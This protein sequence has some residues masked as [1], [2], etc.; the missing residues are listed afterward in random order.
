MYSRVKF[1]EVGTVFGRW[2]F[3][4]PAPARKGVT[5]ISVRCTCGSGIV[6]EVQKSQV[7]NGISTSCGCVM[8]EKTRASNTKHGLKNTPIYGVWR[9]MRRRCEDQNQKDYIRYGGRGVRVCDRWQDVKNFFDDM[10][11]PPPGLSIERLDNSRGYE[12]GNCVWASMEE[13]SRN[14]RNNVYVEFFGSSKILKDWLKITGHS[15]TT[16][17][18]RIRSGLLPGDALVLPSSLCP[19]PEAVIKTFLGCAK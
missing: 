7:T 1:P 16:I 12:P 19:N 18:K 15:E 5:Y 2:E 10:G 4:G 13:Q 11:Q 9:G 8:V 3:L 6:K 17:R 14:K